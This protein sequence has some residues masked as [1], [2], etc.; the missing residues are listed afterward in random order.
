MCI[1]DSCQGLF[2][3]IHSQKSRTLACHLAA[4]YLS[5]TVCKMLPALHAFT[6]CDT[7]SKVGAKKKALD[8]VY[9]D[10]KYVNA[11]STLGDTYQFNY[12]QF[13]ILESLYLQLLGKNGETADDARR[14]IF[15]RSCGI[16]INMANIPCTSDALYQHTLR[17]FTQTYIWKNALYSYYS[18]IDFTQW[19]YYKSE[20]NAILPKFMTK[21]ALPENV[22]KPC[23]CKKTCNTKAFNC[24]KKIV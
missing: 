11:L 8:L 19:G 14:L 13:R 2:F 5:A 7:T 10:K 16:G 1:R 17:A 3:K 22:V 23:K 21:N 20:D 15:N 24:K 6:G 4:E 12:Q 9:V 18:P